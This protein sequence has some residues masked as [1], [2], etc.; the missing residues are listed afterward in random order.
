MSMR[1]R[2]RAL[3]TAQEAQQQCQNKYFAKNIHIGT[4]SYY[5]ILE[6]AEAAK[7]HTNKPM[8]DVVDD[9][10]DFGKTAILVVFF[11]SFKFFFF[12]ANVK[13]LFFDRESH[14]KFI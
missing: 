14:E 7:K 13:F 4:Y 2:W 5:Y 3:Y 9:D 10:K 12:M 11:C 8:N 1:E 6:V